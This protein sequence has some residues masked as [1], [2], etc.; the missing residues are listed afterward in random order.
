MRHST[1]FACYSARFILVSACVSMLSQ[2]RPLVASNKPL[3]A[4]IQAPKSTRI[5]RSLKQQFVRPVVCNSGNLASARSSSELENQVKVVEDKFIPPWSIIKEGVKNDSRFRQHVNP[6]ARRFQM[7]TELP[8]DWPKND[9]DDPTLPLHVDI[10]C[11]KGGFLLDL[12]SKRSEGIDSDSG[13]MKMNYLGLEIRPSVARYARE[14][15]P[16]WGLKGRVSFIGCN[17]N[18][19]LDRILSI[20]CNRGGTVSYVSLQYPDPHFKKS[21]QKR[22]VLTNELVRTLAKFVPAGCD[23]FIQSDIKDVFDDMREKIR[24][25]GKTHFRDV[26]ADFEETLDENPLGVPTEREISV[27]KQDLPVYRTVFRRESGGEP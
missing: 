22:R 3:R 15:V 14:R 8:D 25:H 2:A 16:R 13:A 18:V 19:D 23:V 9:F 21:H 5:D 7:Q 6:L 20:Y 1:E 11:G 12:A 27:L 26:V 4:F 17:A 10:G 24:E